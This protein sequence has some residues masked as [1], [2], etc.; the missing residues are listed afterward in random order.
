MK[1]TDTR[2]IIRKCNLDATQFYDALFDW[3]NGTEKILQSAVFR[4]DRNATARITP[5]IDIG[6]PD[7][8]VRISGGFLTGCFVEWSCNIPFVPIDTTV[9][10]CTS[11]VYCFSKKLIHFSLDDFEKKI[12]QLIEARND[13]SWNF[14][15][16]NHFIILA[17]SEDVN[18]LV[19]HSSAS[20]FKKDMDR[21]LYPV[22]NN[23]YWNSIETLVDGNRYLRF[24][25]EK[26]A[27]IFWKIAEKIPE[28]NIKRHDYFAEKFAKGLTNIIQSYTEHHYGMPTQESI[29]IGCYI[30]EP[31]KIVPI[32]SAPGRCL[33]L[34]KV[35]I[36]D[37]NAGNTKLIPHGWGK[38]CMNLS[39]IELINSMQEIE[40]AGRKYLIN[41]SERI[42]G[43]IRQFC[44]NPMKQNYYFSTMS[45]YYK[46]IVKK[47]LNQKFSYSKHGCLS[48]KLD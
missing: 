6:L 18:Y 26:D 10:V 47:I 38:T 11:S 37:P 35:D 4:L 31:E 43:D 1:Y 2:N 3:L 25:K 29:N 19:M 27:E 42:K 8:V 24:I 20:E 23:W 12:N 7:D 30:T 33:F 48:W 34:Y 17:E 40:I 5:S 44:D 45:K 22:P 39:K 14:N 36:D 9:G 21:G 13:F 41:S 46:G 32:F 15:S 28:Y 16:G